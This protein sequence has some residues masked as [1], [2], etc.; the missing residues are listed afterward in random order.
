MICDCGRPRKF[1]MHYPRYSVVDRLSVEIHADRAAMGTAAAQA[2][3]A[4]LRDVITRQGEARV[5]F[6]CAPSQDEFLL[7]LAAPAARDT[8]VDWS[9]VTVFHM[10]D[11][12]GLDASNPQSFRYYLQQHLLRRVEVGRFYPLPAEES[13]TAAACSRYSAL[14][15][16]KPIDMIFLG[17]GENGHIAFNDPAFADFDD[18]LLVKQ[19]E[20]D[21]VCRQQQ[22]NDGCFASIEEVP[23]AAL[24]LTVPVFRQARR[25]SIHVPGTRKATAVRATLR[26]PITPAC[27]ASILRIHPNATL[28]L[29]VESAQD[30]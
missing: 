12:V 3:A 5:I 2:V 14:L 4:H 26:G 29:D 15:A 8:P 16:E 18:P 25:L 27:P 19:V 17:I 11:Y 6:A 20:L 30:L 9:K 13:D 1:F 24:T 22:V 21:S 28:Y 10:D 7:G 23:K